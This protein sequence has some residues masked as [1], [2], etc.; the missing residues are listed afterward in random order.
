MTHIK[1]FNQLN[2]NIDKYE[3]DLLNKIVIDSEKLEDLAILMTPE[4]IDLLKSIVLNQ[5]K[6]IVELVNSMESLEW[7]SQNHSE[8]E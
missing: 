3:K 5:T 7:N 6:L 8:E 4:T 2:E 1:K